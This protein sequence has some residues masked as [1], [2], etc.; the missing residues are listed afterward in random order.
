MKHKPKGRP[1][2][3]PNRKYIV[4]EAKRANCPHCQSTRYRVLDGYEPHIVMHSG[5][6]PDGTAYDQVE[7]RPS[8]CADCGGM[9]REKTHTKKT[10]AGSISALGSGHKSS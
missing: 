3:A 7:F 1:P 8:Q 10:T 9:F 4:V 5:V 2:G 6:L